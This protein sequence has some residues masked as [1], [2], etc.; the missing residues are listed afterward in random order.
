MPAETPAMIHERTRSYSEVFS[1]GAFAGA[2]SHPERVKLNRDH[3][4]D[5]LL[6]K[7]TALNPW[8]EE[9]LTGTVKL[10]RIRDADEALELIS[11]DM[12]GVSAAFAVDPTAGSMESRGNHRRIRRAI[13]D[14]VSLVAEAAYPTAA[15]TAVRRRSA[16]PRLDAVLELLADAR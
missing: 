15:V 1:H 16:T 2:E 9:G 5:R 10:A 11:L 14:H 4:R 12:L 3:Q 13:L 8:A 7:A 6:G